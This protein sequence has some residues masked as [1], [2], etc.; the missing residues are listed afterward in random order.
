MSLIWLKYMY[1]VLCALK[2]RPMPAA[3][4]WPKYCDIIIKNMKK[5][6]HCP[7]NIWNQLV[8]IRTKMVITSFIH[9]ASAIAFSL[10]AD[11]NASNSA[12]FAASNS[13]NLWSSSWNKSKK[14]KLST[15][16]INSNGMWVKKT[17]PTSGNDL[18]QFSY[19]TVLL[20]QSNPL[21]SKQRPRHLHTSSDNLRNFARSDGYKKSQAPPWILRFP[22]WLWEVKGKPPFSVFTIFATA[23]QLVES[24]FIPKG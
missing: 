7:K 5:E 11:F 20:P 18:H 9:L 4:D 3:I 16:L 8:N 15:G 24:Y 2:W 23:C 21:L 1:S 14:K 22:A 19:C 12:S 13:N 6:F 17:N 10:L